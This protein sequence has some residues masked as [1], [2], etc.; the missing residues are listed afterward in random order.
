MSHMIAL[1]SKVAIAVVA[2]VLAA[3]GSGGSESSASDPAPDATVP[4]ADAA[5]D[6]AADQQAPVAEESPSPT[7]D[8]QVAVEELTLPDEAVAAPDPATLS[9]QDFPRSV[10]HDFGDAEIAEVPERIVATAGVADLD[11]LLSL[12]V[13]PY[14]TALYYPVNFAGDLGLASWNADY[15]DQL[16]TLPRDPSIEEVARLDP[17]LIVGQPGQVTENFALYSEIAPTVVHNYPT[18]WREPLLLFGETLGLEEEANAAIERIE[19]EIDMIAE[20]VPS[21]AP[22]LAM[23]SPLPG[24]QVVIYNENFGAGPARAL[25]GIG[26]EI[27]GPDGP[28]SYE[29]LEELAGAD[30]ILVFDFTLGPVDEFLEDPVFRQLPAVRAGNVVRLSPEQSFSWVIE[31]SRSLPA[32]LD[33]ILGQIGL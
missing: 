24:G 25:S 6:P 23:V 29:R 15:A 1:W 18:D 12:G 32:T 27:V 9:P 22:S 21:D 20:R 10:T 2:L 4:A 3:C 28:I 5:D 16:I 31:T 26:L 33:G 19:N 17:D 13:V 30:W 14:A 8:P 7:V 11:A